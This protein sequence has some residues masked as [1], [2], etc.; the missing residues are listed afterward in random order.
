MSVLQ[1]MDNILNNCPD[2]KRK[3]VTFQES[4]PVPRV[5]DAAPEPRMDEFDNNQQLATKVTSAP[6]VSTT[7]PPPKVKNATKI[8]NKSSCVNPNSGPTTRSK[9]AQALGR[10]V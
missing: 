8:T 7:T 5:I 2:E 6:R 9:Y 1:K 10:L 4:V 3:R